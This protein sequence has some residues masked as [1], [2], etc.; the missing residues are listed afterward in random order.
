METRKA[1]ELYVKIA[2]N[3]L[4]H[5]LNLQNQGDLPVSAREALNSG[6]FNRIEAYIS[7]SNHGSGICKN[8]ASTI[9]EI[10]G[11]FMMNAPETREQYCQYVLFGKSRPSDL[12]PVVIKGVNTFGQ[13][14]LKVLTYVHIDWMERNVND[15]MDASPAMIDR[16]Y[17]FL[18]FE[19]VGWE[20]LRL[21]YLILF[22]LAQDLDFFGDTSLMLCEWAKEYPDAVERSV[23]NEYLLQ[24]GDF[25]RNIVFN[26]YCSDLREY[27]RDY[28][29]NGRHSE[30]PVTVQLALRDDGS[31]MVANKVA[32]QL[33]EVWQMPK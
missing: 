13:M 32:R 3:C 1:G 6:D 10:F 27:L 29:G 7:D 16:R 30:V 33:K 28:V 12:N 17:L 11:G 19:M 23:R 24:S 26:C 15:F 5:I 31:N 25:F 4:G 18:P 9:K 21:D 20:A 2:T 14:A 22:A 8:I